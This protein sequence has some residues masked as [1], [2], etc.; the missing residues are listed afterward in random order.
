M[1]IKEPIWNEE[2]LH[3]IKILARA[4]YD[5]QSERI[6]I[7]GQMGIKKSGELKKGVPVRDEALLLFLHKRHSDL[8][9]ILNTLEKQLKKEVKHHPVWKL[10]LKE[11]TGC[12]ETMAAVILTQFDINKAETVSKM[13]QFSGMNPGMVYGKKKDDDGNIVVTDHLVRGDHKTH[14]Y[15]CPYN[16][17]LK[18]KL[19]GVLGSSFLKSKSS[20]AKFYYDEKLRLENSEV[21]TREV[22]KGGKEKMIPWNE[23]K[24]NHR[25]LAA[26]RK[27][28]KEFLKDLYDNWRTIAGLPVREPYA[29]EYLGKNAHIQKA[30]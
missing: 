19:L 9:G 29:V 22:S 16:A 26:M 11:V 24:L 18:T 10:Y 13:W 28:V 8:K 6:R 12:G 25:H 5:Y 21:V 4:Y 7:E 14:G 20:F 27:M 2:M 23:T 3:S 30:A 17:F 15:L 1:K